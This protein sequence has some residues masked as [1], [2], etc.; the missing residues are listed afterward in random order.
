MKKFIP[1]L[2]LV[3]ICASGIWYASSQS[4]FQEPPVN[5]EIP[6]V[7]L[8]DRI[9]EVVK[10]SIQTTE[11]TVELSKQEDGWVMEQ[12]ASYPVNLF[13]VDSWLT[14]FAGITY[15]DL[16]DE[17]PADL[18]EFG[19]EAPERRFDLI[20]NDG[21]TYTIMTGNASPVSDHYYAKLENAPEVYTIAGTAVQSL[22]KQPLDLIEKNVFKINY[23][24]VQSIDFT[25][26]E[27]HWLLAK[28][29]PD[30]APYE[31][32]WKLDGT[33]RE[34]SEGAS[35]LDKMTTIYTGQLPVSVEEKAME[36]PEL[37]IKVKEGDGEQ[38]SEVTFA[39]KIEGEL[40]WVHKVGSPWI[41]SA[42][43]AD[44]DS[45]FQLGQLEDEASEDGPA[46]DAA[47][48]DEP[49]DDVTTGE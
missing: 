47:A 39:G 26:R 9:Q 38:A 35:I 22:S 16:V 15:T 36:Q 42:N 17:E 29:E 5:E 11:G 14:A 30:K 6:L 8:G 19:L 18:D 23:D 41:Y 49:T 7:S 12:P 1:T 27:K 21:T 4:W 43:V 44:I 13:M 10:I 33:Q 46:E 28:L 40:I 20:L 34:A 45:W 2:L 3:V 31:S 37:Q 48:G 25:W 24:K 32:A